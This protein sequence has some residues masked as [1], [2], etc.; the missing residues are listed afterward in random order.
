MSDKLAFIFPGQGSQ[1]VG[2]LD[3]F[4]ADN[5]DL[6][7]DI[8][9]EASSVL[10]YDMLELIAKDP[11]QRLNQTEYTQPALLTAGFV[12]W[13]NWQ[14]SCDE[15]PILLAGH[16]LGEYTALVCAGAITFSAGLKLV[17]KRGQLM[18]SAVPSGQGAMAAIL[19]LEL[20]QVDEICA[21]VD[22]QAA[23][24][25]APGQIVVAGTTAGVDLVIEKAK[26]QGAKRALL[27]PVSVPSH[28]YLMHEAAVQLGEELRN[29]DW[30]VPKIKVVHNFDVMSHADSDG[31]CNALEKQLF[32]PVRWTECIEYMVQQGVSEFLECGPGKVLTGLNKRIVPTIPTRAMSEHL[33]VGLC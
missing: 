9:A 6:V 1:S 13:K 32:S 8:C 11:E 26:S 30:S 22:A 17:A 29:L 25:N 5:P 21:N 2:M 28:C 7:A 33:G 19:G 15:Q 31:I 23:N 10:G 24:I 14:E 16:S 27:L 20:S 3:P 18:Q 4:I 12:A